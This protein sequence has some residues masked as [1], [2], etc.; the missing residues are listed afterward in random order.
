MC[1]FQF[2]LKAQTIYTPFGK[3][4]I[5]FQ[6]HFNDWWYYDTE[7][8]TLMWYGKERNLAKSVIM[9]SQTT[10]DE[11]E[12]FLDFKINH[13]IEVI[14]YA[15]IDDYNQSNIGVKHTSE[16]QNIVKS[17]L[18]YNKIVVYFDGNFNNLMYQIKRGTA[19]MFIDEL[20][21][22]R[23]NSNLYNRLLNNKYPQWL[24]E[25]TAEYL[26]GLWTQKDQELLNYIFYHNSKSNL[27]FKILSEKYPELIGSS[28]F[29][30]LENKYG[31]ETIS[32]FFSLLRVTHNLKNS[33][34]GSFEKN[35]TDLTN[36]WKSYSADN[37]NS[38]EPK[39]FFKQIKSNKHTSFNYPIKNLCVDKSGD[40]IAVV[41][42]NNG[43]FD[44]FIRKS[45]KS[46]FVKIF[47]CGISSEFLKED[48]EYPIVF[49]NEKGD[50]LFI[51]NFSKGRLIL[52]S[53]DIENS[54]F[55]KEI[56]SPV[57][58][59]IYSASQVGKNN[60]IFVADIDGLTDLF[61]Y[62][63]EKKQITRLTEDIWIE[64]DVS[65]VDF[66]DGKKL[67]YSSNRPSELSS[68][69][70][71]GDSLPPMNKFNIYTFDLIK[72]NMKK[73]TSSKNFNFIKPKLINNDLFALAQ[74][75]E[76]NIIFQ[77]SIQSLDSTA[78][79]SDEKHVVNDFCIAKDDF[80]LT[81]KVMF[82]NVLFKYKI[83]D[84][85]N[86]SFIENVKNDKTIV[87]KNDQNHIK[88]SERNDFEI[89]SGLM[90][91]S[92]FISPAKNDWKEIET[93][94]NQEKTLTKQLV[95]FE[96]YKAVALRYRFN[97]ERI[98]AKIDNEE[99]FDGM[100]LYDLKHNFYQPPQAGLLV[101]SIIHDKFEN[102]FLEG[103]FRISPN[104]DQ[105]EY[106][107]IYDNLKNKVDWK[108]AFYKKILSEENNSRPNVL[109]KTK[110]IINALMVERLYPFDIQKSLKI[111]ARFQINNT[112]ETS[113]DSITLNSI[114]NNEQRLGL[115]CEYVYDNT[116]L[117]GVN[118]PE[119]LKYK[120]FLEANN[121]L[122]ISFSK[123]NDI[124][125]SKGIMSVIGMD[126]RK[127]ITLFGKTTLAL[128]TASQIS[129]GND[130]NIYFLG[131]MENWYFN[132]NSNLISPLNNDN[133]AFKILVANMRGFGY[134]A[135]IGDKF[136]VFNSELRIPLMRYIFGQSLKKTYL[137]DFQVAAFFDA[138]I[139]WFGLT[140]FSESN[141]A[142]YKVI[143]APP[144]IKIRLR[145]YTDPLISGFGVGARTSLFGYYIKL[146][147]GWG[148]ETR[149][150]T[151]PITY[152][153]IGY[154][155]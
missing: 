91:Q 137:R 85:I 44:I 142:N 7:N 106:F 89:D 144:A 151:K 101:K 68:T 11:I 126:V 28:F 12:N 27:N 132:K 55:E 30:F 139:A 94:S 56:L 138:G 69:Y 42:T 107:L 26:A 51:I 48:R 82:D 153:T 65:V 147:Y 17:K 37:T 109:G 90:F 117:I 99:L 34:Y 148:I 41:T 70:F 124:K 33:L 95:Q 38:V 14:I 2:D 63:I 102:Y 36:E 39:I 31:V 146:D 86:N 112:I 88:S 50:Q 104:L 103:G 64:K 97:Y 32:D 98:T 5:Q 46:K 73:L 141:P 1:S 110:Y 116:T 72:G 131:G 74:N 135:R 125:I 53:Y 16:Y 40:K 8:Y 154:D 128:R 9:M 129:F 78:F 130:R 83:S 108:L 81:Y 145:Y 20:L 150:I 155:F 10:Y 23:E 58:N 134:N 105:K 67:L 118:Q 3:N 47:K 25:G 121:K 76:N 49:F 133:Y 122:G 66:K 62:N 19:Y 140:P 119:G 60:L 61:I 13:K 127:Y 143:Y 71:P 77:Q 52:L 54:Q 6:K 120:F 96:S 21:N 29:N 152:L 136:L 35:F 92:R 15:N 75:D 111:S 22:G 59:K 87:G 4:I 43:K 79:V 113:T 115:K 80:F 45:A 57:F 93:L 149:S 114:N 84:V 18:D 123:F 24:L 100:S